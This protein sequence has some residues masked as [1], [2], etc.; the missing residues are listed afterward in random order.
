MRLILLP[1]IKAL[2]VPSIS[3][4]GFGI[5]SNGMPLGMS[6]VGVEHDDAHLLKVAARVS[7]VFDQNGEWK[8]KL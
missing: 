7:K 1:H 3:L 4:P 6:I 2:H 8:T 5:E